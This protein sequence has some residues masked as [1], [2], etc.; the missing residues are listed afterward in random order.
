MKRVLPSFAL[1]GGGFTPTK[2]KSRSKQADVEPTSSVAETEVILNVPASDDGD[3]VS[4]S[5]GLMDPSLGNNSSRI[6]TWTVASSVY[7]FALSCRFS[8]KTNPSSFFVFAD[9]DSS[10]KYS[11]HNLTRRATLR[12]AE[13]DGSL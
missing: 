6:H 1:A 2:A 13:G 8:R 7:N 12:Q 10:N 5:V 9:L 4:S 3:R 11:S